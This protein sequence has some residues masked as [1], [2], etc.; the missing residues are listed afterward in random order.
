MRNTLSIALALAFC[1]LLAVPG[2]AQSEDNSIPLGDVARRVREARAAQRA[3][4]PAQPVPAAVSPQT[5]VITPPEPAAPSLGDLARQLRRERFVRTNTVTI[6]N[7]NLPQV[8]QEAANRSQNKSPLFTFEK[9]AKMFQVS[10]SPDMNCSLSFNA[11]AAPV[12]NS[13]FIAESLPENEL[14]KLDGPAAVDGDSLQLNVFNG[15]NYNLREITVGV[16]IV[17]KPQAVPGLISAPQLLPTVT[18]AQP[19]IA[20][21]EKKQDLTVLYHIKGTAAPGSTT[22]FKAALDAPVA[23]DQEWHWAIVDAKGV[24]VPTPAQVSAGTDPTAR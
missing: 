15:S 14:E 10:F 19:L 16:T 9:A 1:F 12:L 8:M 21:I 11:D 24:L 5:V 7:D 13:A 20:Q 4:P 3:Q 17:R 18:T 6:D 2:F 23:P 22:L